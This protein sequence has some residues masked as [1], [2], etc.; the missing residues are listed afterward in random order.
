ML[1]VFFI[2]DSLFGVKYVHLNRA[3][4]ITRMNVLSLNIVFNAL[5][6]FP[7]EDVVKEL[8]SANHLE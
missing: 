6:Y 1:D 4:D 2:S 7:I 5:A 3:A 8:P